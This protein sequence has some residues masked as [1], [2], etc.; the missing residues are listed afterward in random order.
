VTRRK[1]TLQK[2]KTLSTPGCRRDL[3]RYACEGKTQV[4][5]K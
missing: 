5:N 4:R 3:R 1:S 2:P